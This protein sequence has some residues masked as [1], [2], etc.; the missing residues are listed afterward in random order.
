M[1]IVTVTGCFD[2]LHS[3]H[4]KLLERASKLGNKLVVGLNSDRSVRALK[5][6]ERPVNSQFSRKKI[7]DS[8]RF[9]DEVLLFDND[10]VTEFLLFL[11]PAIWVK[12]GYTMQTLNQT[13]VAVAQSIGCKIVLYP[14]IDN[15]SSTKIIAKLQ[16]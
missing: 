12:G 13:E 2:I 16:R 6:S 9:V 7:I 14:A 5:G 1:Q 4:V 8:I 10:T 15:I 3:G 11:R